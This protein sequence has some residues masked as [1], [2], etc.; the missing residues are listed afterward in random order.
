MDFPCFFAGKVTSAVILLDVCSEVNAVDLVR[1]TPL[2]LALRA[3][4]AYDIAVQLTSTLLRYGA[5]PTLLGRDDDMPIDVA[6]QT[7]QDYCLELLEDALGKKGCLCKIVVR[8]GS[9]KD[10]PIND[11]PNVCVLP[12]FVV[13]HCI[14]MCHVASSLLRKLMFQVIIYCNNK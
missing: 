5:S 3:N 2:H 9:G 4:H 12:F 1:D 8:L 14:V 13:F 7:Y 10:R 11:K 6:K